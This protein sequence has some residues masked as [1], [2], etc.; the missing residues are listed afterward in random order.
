MGTFPQREEA[1]ASLELLVAEEVQEG[2]Q[3]VAVPCRLQPRPQVLADLGV[4]LR[5][6]RRAQH[7]DAQQLP[8]D[9]CSQRVCHFSLL[10]CKL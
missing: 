8:G 7:L 6:S 3:Q 1:G 5:H 9:M 2:L 10:A 4:K